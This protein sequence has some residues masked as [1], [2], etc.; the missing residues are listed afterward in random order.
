MSKW[1]SFLDIVTTITILV[2]C[3]LVIRTVS[4]RRRPVTPVPTEPMS[5]RGLDAK[6]NPDSP[7]VIVEWADYECSYCAVIES[8]VIPVLQDRYIRTGKAQLVVR[9]LPLAGIHPQAEAAAQAAACAGAQGRF[10]DMHS[11]LFERQTN[12]DDASLLQLA[13]ELALD[14]EHF[15]SCVSG[16][17]SARVRADVEA[18]R[19]LGFNSTPAFL[20]G[21]RLSN[22]DMQPAAVI[23]GAKPVSEFVEAVERLLAGDPGIQGIPTLTVF[24]IIGGVVVVGLAVLRAVRGAPRSPSGLRSST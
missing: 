17:A 12:L 18:A 1:R 14:E 7:V 16:E 6:G 4:P 8:Q 9:H 19:A 2:T 21:F 22:G 23:T 20:V 15:V 13:R 5:L 10:W 3:L 24:G 11:A